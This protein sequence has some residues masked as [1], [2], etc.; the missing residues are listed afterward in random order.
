LFFQSRK[1][2]AKPLKILSFLCFH[3]FQAAME[4]ISKKKLKLKSN[5]AFFIL[6]KK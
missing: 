2:G 5:L 4:K 6:S 1:E 3:I